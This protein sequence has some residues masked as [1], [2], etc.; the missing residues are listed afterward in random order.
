MDPNFAHLVFLCFQFAFFAGL[1]YLPYKA[2]M[3]MTRGAVKTGR[4]TYNAFSPP[5]K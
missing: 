2:V 3:F 1:L 4:K 5:K